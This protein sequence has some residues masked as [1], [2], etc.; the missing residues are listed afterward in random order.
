MLRKTMPGGVPRTRP[1]ERPST[2]PT[3]RYGSI[4]IENASGIS[5]G[6]PTRMG[7]AFVGEPGEIGKHGSDEVAMMGVGWAETGGV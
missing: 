1:G 2:G 6:E 3:F 4:F 7:S 5:R